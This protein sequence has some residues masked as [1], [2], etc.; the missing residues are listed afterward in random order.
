MGDSPLNIL[1]VTAPGMVGG[2]ETVVGSLAT[3]L[4]KR[5]HRVTVSA[6]VTPPSEPHPFVDR[7]R[8]G[9]V[10]VILPPERRLAERR[11]IIALAA[12][13]GGRDRALARLSFRCPGPLRSVG[14][15]AADREHCS[16]LHRRGHQGAVL[17][18]APASG[19]A[20]I[21]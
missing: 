15:S 1:L 17:R 18:M 10:G 16:R 8:A 21:R 5:G 9:G 20:R 4:A 12:K 3:G 2:L 13:T 7:L 11:E 14:H 19:V 6:T